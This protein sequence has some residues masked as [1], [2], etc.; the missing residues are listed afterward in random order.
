MKT[1]AALVTAAILLATPAFAAKS[2]LL[3]AGPASHRP[4]EHEHPAG[5]ALLADH[6]QSSGLPVTVEV[7]HGWPAD[8]AKVAGAD[9]ILIYGDGLQF[10]PAKDHLPALEQHYQ[11]GKGLGILHWALEPANPEM[12]EFFTRAIGGKFEVN[13]SVNPVWDMKD[14]VFSKHQCS[15]GV[16]PFD[17]TEEFYYHIR[18]RQDVTSVFRA[19]P[20]ASSLGKD[21]PR[22]GNPS[23]R[24][25][26]ANQQPQTLAWIVE[27]P[28]GSRGFGFTG[29][30]FHANWASEPF[31]KIVLNAIVWTAGINVP[32][33]GVQGKVAE[34]PMHPS[35]DVAIAKDDLADVKRH[36]AADPQ[37]LNTGAKEKSRAPLEQAILR[38][39]SA[40]ALHLISAGADVNVINS[41]QRT[42][43]HLA[44][45]RGLPQVVSALVKAGAKTDLL[46]KDGWTPL[47]HAAAKDEIESAT[48]L[49][50]GGAN[51]KTLSG[52]GG[53]PLHEAAASG[54]AAMVKLLLAQRIDPT[55][56]SK[57]GVTALDIAREYKNQPA[58]DIL[59]KLNK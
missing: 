43:L 22:S 32:A 10:H 26:L 48:I 13:H 33:D 46:D 1:P 23:V 5:C 29:G 9:S 51:P 54:S 12:G 28:N 14:P 55:I 53:T 11:A 3:I 25:A 56:K 44:V 17:I 35:I 59:S 15:N 41:S 21:G 47:H 38:K 37:K 16:T 49:I 40:I 50:N 7:S 19:L 30:H 52:L 58:I 45:Q 34:Q 36:I 27:N 8:P 24:K 2:I 18:L 57:T 4:G 42:P 20:P 39:K 6:L 31:R